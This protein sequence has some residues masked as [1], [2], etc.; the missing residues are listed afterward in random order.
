MLHGCNFVVTEAIVQTLP[1]WVHLPSQPEADQQKLQFYRKAGFPNVI[2]CI[3]GTH[4]KILAPAVNEHEF[5]NRK[6]QH[7]INVQVCRVDSNPSVS[8]TC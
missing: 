5:V 2:G 3:D 7:S 6:N 4:V 8:V 1:H